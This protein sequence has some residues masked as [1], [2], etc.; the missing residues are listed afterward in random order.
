MRVLIDTNILIS[1]VL[2]HGTPFQ[3][4]LK[5]VSYPNQGLVCTQNIDEMRRIFNRKFPKK[6]SAME[7]FLSLAIPTL[8]LVQI[9][10]DVVEQEEAI[11]DVNDRPIMRSAVAAR[12]DIV[13]TG[14]KDFLESGITRPQIMTAAEFLNV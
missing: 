14:D 5:A 12:A 7:R 1:S 3:A 13:L 4:Y 10:D 6:I 2:G 9:P 8:E 11:R